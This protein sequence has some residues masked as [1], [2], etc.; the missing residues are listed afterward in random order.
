MTSTPR[1]RRRIFSSNA[2]THRP[3]PRR[4]CRLPSSRRRVD[5]PRVQRLRWDRQL[6]AFIDRRRHGLTTRLLPN[7]TACDCAVNRAGRTGPSLPQPSRWQRSAACLSLNVPWRSSRN[8]SGTNVST[9]CG[10]PSWRSSRPVYPSCSSSFVQP[11]IVPPLNDECADQVP[12]Q[13]PPTAETPTIRPHS[14]RRLIA[15]GKRH[16]GP[17][18]GRDGSEHEK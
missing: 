10:V 8:H 14:P 3:H 4:S 9:V 2:N 15:T 12:A 6:E 17:H 13:H 7:V 11:A 16:S 5:G 1:S 18:R